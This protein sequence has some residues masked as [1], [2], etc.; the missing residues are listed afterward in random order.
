[1]SILK[2]KPGDV[3]IDT[4]PEFAGYTYR[5]L[6]TD[7]ARYYYNVYF[8]DTLERTTLRVMWDIF[9]PETRLQTKLDK[10]LK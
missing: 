10:V 4:R 7:K 6:R 9:E 8:K 1:M 3:V 2:Y 5:V